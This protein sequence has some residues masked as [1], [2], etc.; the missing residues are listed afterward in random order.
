MFKNLK[1]KLL[2]DKASV[3]PRFPSHRKGSDEILGDAK[4]PKKSLVSINDFYCDKGTSSGDSQ[5]PV[6]TAAPVVSTHK[7]SSVKTS[8]KV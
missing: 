4:S 3:N 6:A 2:G 7:E 8:S 5:E 1:E